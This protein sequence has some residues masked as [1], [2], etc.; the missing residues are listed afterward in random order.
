[1]ADTQFSVQK[2]CEDCEEASNELML[3]DEEYV[4]RCLDCSL[5]ITLYIIRDFT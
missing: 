1:M 5:C 3:N 4:R 2:L